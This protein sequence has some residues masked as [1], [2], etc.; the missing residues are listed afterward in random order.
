MAPLGTIRIDTHDAPIAIV[1]RVDEL[2]VDEAEAIARDPAVLEQFE[3]EV[4][5]D[6]RSAL[7]DLAL[8]S[9]LVAML[10]GILGAWPET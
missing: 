9:L 3:S 10:G 4:V 2:R 8:R 6:A 5:D 7:R 1:A